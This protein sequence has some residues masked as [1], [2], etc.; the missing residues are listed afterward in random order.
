M[1]TCPLQRDE[2]FLLYNTLEK[3][4]N[5]V[6]VKDHVSLSLVRMKIAL[7]RLSVLV[8]LFEN[9]NYI[10]F[11]SS[12]YPPQVSLSSYFGYLRAGKPEAAEQLKP[13]TDG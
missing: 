9:D 6:A 8:C 12:N 13:S 3:L 7:L 10:I 1:L 2:A 11:I 4:F 5:T